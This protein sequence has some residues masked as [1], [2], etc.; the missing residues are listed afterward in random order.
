[1]RI[2]ADQLLLG[3]TRSSAPKARG[4]KARVSYSGSG[5]NAYTAFLNDVLGGGTNGQRRNIDDVR[6]EYRTL[7]PEK[8]AMYEQA[9]EQAREARR[10]GRKRAFPR[11]GDSWKGTDL[12][13]SG[14][15]DL[16]PVTDTPVDELVRKLKQES[17]VATIAR[18]AAEQEERAA[19]MSHSQ[20]DTSEGH[21]AAAAGQ[22][23][24]V[25]VL[26]CLVI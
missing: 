5:V 6:K 7:P 18:K 10:A 26:S 24:R 21:Y 20:F 9:A 2:E 22:L 8:L 16:V 12:V 1:V 11:W 3:A 19:L 15:T 13:A 4:E 25:W 14:P 23:G 17:R